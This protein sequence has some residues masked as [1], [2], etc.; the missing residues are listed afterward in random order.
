LPSFAQNFKQRSRLRR[1]LRREESVGSAS[2]TCTPSTPDTVNVVFDT[3]RKVKV[4]DKL[5]VLDV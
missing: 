1:I 3:V 4:D 2:G 5:D